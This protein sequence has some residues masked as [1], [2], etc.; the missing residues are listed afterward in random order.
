MAVLSTAPLLLSFLSF[1]VIGSYYF[2]KT[3]IIFWT[4]SSIL[5]AI[6]IS[7]KIQNIDKFKELI[8]RYNFRL[9]LTQIFIVVP[10]FSFLT[11]KVNSLNIYNNDKVI[12]VEFMKNEAGDPKKKKF[13]KLLGFIGEKVIISDLKNEKIQIVN[14]SSFDQIQLIEKK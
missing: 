13:V 3:N 8:P 1:A 9:Y 14:Q 2:F 5:F 12:L 4:I 11:G 7:I 6:L 10:I